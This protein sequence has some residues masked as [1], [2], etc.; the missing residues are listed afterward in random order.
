MTIRECNCPLAFMALADGDIDA[1]ETSMSRYLAGCDGD[2]IP[3]TTEQEHLATLD[4]QASQGAPL[5]SFGPFPQEYG[6][7]VLVGCNLSE[8]YAY[9]L[10][11]VCEDCGRVAEISTW[12]GGH[13]CCRKCRQSALFYADQHGILAEVGPCPTCGQ[14]YCF[15]TAEAP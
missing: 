2:E 13:T 12:K 14:R 3:L 6:E 5:H 8:L 11:A 7:V 15:C 9:R 10:T 4:E 1:F